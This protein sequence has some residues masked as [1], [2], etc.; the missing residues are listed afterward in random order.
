[1]AKPKKKAKANAAKPTKRKPR[2]P[3]LPGME[4]AGIAALEKIAEEYADVRD[5]R[6]ALSKREGEMQDD[7]LALMKKHRKTEYHH[8][9]VH[10]WVQVT[11]EKVKVKI[12]ELT[13]A[14][15]KKESAQ[16]NQNQEPEETG[17]A[18]TLE[19]EQPAEVA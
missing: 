8:E 19:Q 2:T 7:L 9:D 1:M 14:R 12:G 17:E 4:D 6:I 11:E 18:E 5:D 3:R 10:V 16:T 15:A 13:P